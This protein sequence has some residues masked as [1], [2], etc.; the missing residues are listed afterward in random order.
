MEVREATEDD[1][2]A[3]RGVAEQ[4][5]QASYSLSPDAIGQ[6]VAEWYDPDRLAEKLDDDGVLLLVAEDETDGVVAFSESAFLGEGRA[7]LLWLHVSPPYRGQGLGDDLF[8]ATADRLRD[9]GAESVRGRVLADNV[10]GNEFYEAKGFRRVGQGE[11]DIGGEDYVE[12][13]YLDAGRTDLDVRSIDDREVY[14]D[15]DDTERGSDAPFYVVYEDPDRER[16]YS[17]LCGN[18]DALV[19]S[20]GAMGNM[21]C[22]ECGNESKPTRWDAAYG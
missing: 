11:V 8:E 14:I 6:A 10:E 17:Y 21:E 18:C 7:D 12:N 15:R 9:G 16:K 22:E 1:G 3:V 20:M 5:M 13:V 19:T 4:S 2:P